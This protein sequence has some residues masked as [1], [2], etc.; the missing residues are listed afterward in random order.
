MNSFSVAK[1]RLGLA[2]KA[3]A[4][5]MDRATANGLAAVEEITQRLN[6][7][8]VHGPLYKLFTVEDR[9]KLAVEVTAGQR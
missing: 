8:G 2:Q 1:D 7:S 4:S 9:Y 5:T 3:L 6:L